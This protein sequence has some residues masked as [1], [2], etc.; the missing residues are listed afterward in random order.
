MLKQQTQNSTIKVSRNLRISL[1]FEYEKKFKTKGF[2]TK[3]KRQLHHMLRNK[4]RLSQTK[5]QNLKKK[6]MT[7]CKTLKTSIILTLSYRKNE[8]DDMKK[9]LRKVNQVP[10]KK[11]EQL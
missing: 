7:E 2:T 8:I 1:H 10:R 11:R 9:E 5:N 4:N 6:V 3:L